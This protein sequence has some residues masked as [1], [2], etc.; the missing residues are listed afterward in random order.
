M[1]FERADV[2]LAASILLETAS[3]CILKHTN[4]RSEYYIPS[5]AGYAISF[6]MFPKALIKYPLYVAYTIWCGC[7]IILVACYDAAVELSVP[8]PHQI[9]G[10][11]CVIVGI[12][13]TCVDATTLYFV[14]K[15]EFSIVAT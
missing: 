9:C 10:M 8:C 6:Y 11:L 5:Y 12:F 13:L 7:G 4:S 2:Y 14:H 3:T 1:I 15:Q